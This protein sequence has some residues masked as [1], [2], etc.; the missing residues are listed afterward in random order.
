MPPKHSESSFDQESENAK[1]IDRL[2]EAVK[3]LTDTVQT[4]TTTLTAYTAAQAVR[5]E[6]ANQTLKKV[7]NIV[8][9]RDENPGLSSKVEG[10]NLQM[11]WVMGIV[12]ALSST[13]LGLTV[14]LISKKLGI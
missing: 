1:A 11:K 6:S 7:E 12:T 14:H 3:A 13:T 8:C 9:G 10:L 5:C 4:L 2:E